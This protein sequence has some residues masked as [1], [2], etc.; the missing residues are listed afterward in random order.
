MVATG[1]VNSRPLAVLAALP[2]Y[3]AGTWIRVRGEETLL[4]AAFGEAF[5]AYVRRVPAVLPFTRPAVPSA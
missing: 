5:E 2:F 3:A 4:R 1:L